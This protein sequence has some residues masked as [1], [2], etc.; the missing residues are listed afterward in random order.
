MTEERLCPLF[1]VP[2]KKERCAWWYRDEKRCAL[3]VIAANLWVIGTEVAE[4]GS[5]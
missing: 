5:L 1:R 4:G 2:C 3:I